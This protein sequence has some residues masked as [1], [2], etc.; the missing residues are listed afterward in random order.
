MAIYHALED[1]YV[2]LVLD[3]GVEPHVNN[4]EQHF[5]FY[6]FVWVLEISHIE[7]HNNNSKNWSSTFDLSC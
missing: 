4:I 7:P 2:G 3:V 6:S 5:L 1:I